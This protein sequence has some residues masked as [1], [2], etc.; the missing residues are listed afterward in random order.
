MTHGTELCN[1]LLNYSGT[2][3]YIF[4]PVD[5][6]SIVEDVTQLIRL[7]V[8]KNATTRFDLAG[9]PRSTRMPPSCDR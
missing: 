3:G 9:S 5:L 1:Q 6:D 7:A 2:G 8:S 4:E